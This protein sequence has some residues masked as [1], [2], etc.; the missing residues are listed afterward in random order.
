MN[1]TSGGKKTEK[2]TYSHNH[3]QT[4]NSLKMVMGYCSWHDCDQ[5]H[6]SKNNGQ[7]S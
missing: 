6:Y 5:A 2:D 7:F 3:W 4:S 1:I